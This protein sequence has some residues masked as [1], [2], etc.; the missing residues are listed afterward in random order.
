MFVDRIKYIEKKG[1]EKK[2]PKEKLPLSGIFNIKV[3]HLNFDVLSIASDDTSVKD[4][5]IIK[6]FFDFT[7]EKWVDWSKEEGVFIDVGAHT[8]FYSLAALKNHEKNI[9]VAIE[10]LQIN[11]YRILTNLRLNHLQSCGRFEILNYAVSNEDK[12]V[13]FSTKSAWT[14]LSKGGKI[15]NS[16]MKIKAIKLDSLDLSSLNTKVIA[17]KV[18]TEGHDLESLQG[19]YNL[20][21]SH[22]PKIIVETR[23]NNAEAIFKFL[24][25]LGYKNIYDENNTH[26]SSEKTLSFQGKEESKDI[27]CE[28]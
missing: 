18:D 15:S 20:I 28:F 2:I 5:Y 22:L 4:R 12:F 23:R 6:N 9:V 13:H 26:I 17:L 27:F 10:P 25:E 11:F 21:K 24:H 7:L 14:F 3:K 1:E 8:G 19:G 16:G